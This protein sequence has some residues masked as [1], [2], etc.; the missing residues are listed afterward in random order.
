MK[1]YSFL[2]ILTTVLLWSCNSRR[3]PTTVET[4]ATLQE[5][6]ELAT[7]EYTISKVVKA[8][9]NKTWYKIGDRKILITC[10][11]TVKAGIDMTD[12]SEK[13]ISLSEKSIRIRLPQPKVLSVNLPPEGIQVAF[14][15]IAFFRKEFTS[16]ERDD[17]LKQAEQ[18]IR[19]SGSELGILE[20]AKTNTQ[21]FL[22]KFLLQ[23]GF[24]KV[25][26]SFDDKEVEP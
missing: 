16:A 3:L 23:L 6:Q 18:Q 9:D 13:N 21:L 11:A 2:I 14:E 1:N 17:L 12:L 8:N 26:I 7:V 20:Q 25:E 5:M 4:V 22:S 15:E 24:E 19:N 10:Q